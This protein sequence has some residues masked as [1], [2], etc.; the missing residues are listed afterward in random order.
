MAPHQPL[1]DGDAAM[2]EPPLS[3]VFE[4][5]QTRELTAR[6]QWEVTHLHRRVVWRKGAG[7]LYGTLTYLWYGFGAFLA[8]SILMAA[9]RLAATAPILAGQ[10][11]V[12]AVGYAVFMVAERWWT[13]RLYRAKYWT[14]RQTG[15]LYAVTADGIRA[16]SRCGTFS[17]SWDSIEAVINN[18][19]HVLAMLPRI[20]SLF[21]VK[22]AFESQ[23]VESFGTELVRRWQGRRV[24]A[25]S[26][27]PA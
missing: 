7:W 2:T 12:A 14:E 26:G 27:S 6:E 5:R 22:A 8:L 24:E 21:I 20:R 23:D 18:D 16:T 11:A 4:L 17:C 25:K 10:L 15:D 3:P 19:R 1:R 13:K 9:K